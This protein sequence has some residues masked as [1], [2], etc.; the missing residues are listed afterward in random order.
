MIVPAIVLVYGGDGGNI[1][2]VGDFVYRGVFM[3]G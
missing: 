2:S 3:M 1:V